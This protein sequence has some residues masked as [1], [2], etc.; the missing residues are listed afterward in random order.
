MTKEEAVRFITNNYAFIQNDVQS[1]K[2]YVKD[3]TTNAPEIGNNKQSFAAWR[4]G[5]FD[6]K[7]ASDVEAKEATDGDVIPSVILI[8]SSNITTNLNNGIKK[9]AVTAEGVIEEDFD[10]EDVELE[11]DV[12]STLAE[13]GDLTWDKIASTYI[14]QS[15][16]IT[17]IN[18]IKELI[19][20]DPV[21]FISKL[22]ESFSK[23]LIHQ[24]VRLKQKLI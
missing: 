5:E 11:F 24:L 2:D 13:R 18:G 22:K 14:G 9:Q 15:I 3:R 6:I 7:Q 8:T 17:E 23:N 19:E 16:S 10:I 12:L 1:I 4:R 20:S 21:G